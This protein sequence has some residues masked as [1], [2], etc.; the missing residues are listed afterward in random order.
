MGYASSIALPLKSEGKT[1][2]A[3]NIY[4][5]KADAFDEDEVRLLTEL[6]DDLAFGITSIRTSKAR[7]LVDEEFQT[8]SKRQQ[9]IL[10]AVPDIIMEVDTNKIYTWV[11]QSGFEFFGKD[12]IG[13]EASFYFEG[14][15]DTYG[16]VQHLFNGDEN[17]FY[18]ESWQRRKDGQIRLLAWWC[19]VLKD[20]QGNVMSVLS[21]ARDIT[22]HKQAEEE[23]RRHRQHLEELVEE[24]TEEIKRINE[25][26][27]QANIHLLEIDKL[28]SIFLASMSHELRTPLN[29]IIGFTGIMLMGMTG[30]LTKEQKKQLAMVKN[31][32][33]HLLDLI[34]DLLDIS[35]I[36][37]GK[38][39][40]S[41][42]EFNFS[43]VVNEVKDTLSAKLMEKGLELI[44][45]GQEDIHIYSDRL[46][47][48]QVLMNLVANAVKFTEKGGIKI[49]SEVVED[50][51]RVSVIDTGMGIN[52]EDMDIL[53]EPFQQID[54]STTKEFE[55]TGLGLYL[56]KK[57][58]ILMGGDIFAES[59]FGKGS[60]FVF[61]VPLKYEAPNE[62]DISD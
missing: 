50:K 38:V 8:L 57:I 37:A 35:K 51:L 58:V 3:L 33:N 45:V 10:S 1:F 28:K 31:S 17:L 23:L 11:N 18:V 61:T 44:S 21:S 39:K 46:R 47:I 56:C 29:S 5:A 49:T 53:F 41:P 30:E 15:Q 16:L 6:T 24:R 48:K 43:Q 20:E 60:E 14:E 59:D 2:G 52:A 12:V 7:K 62:K 54:M 32:A 34:N 55:G 4:S 19:Q 40:I 42:E 27:T 26:L 25:E 9:A 36:E 22:E 13:K